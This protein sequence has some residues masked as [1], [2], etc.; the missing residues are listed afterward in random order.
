[1]LHL[2]YK[3]VFTDCNDAGQVNGTAAAYGNGNLVVGL[4]NISNMWSR[5]S[6][7][8]NRRKALELRSK[9]IFLVDCKE[10]CISA[11]I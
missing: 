7:M 9:F 6:W 3:N 2:V 8:N 10:N 4:V 5:K 1:M 11:E